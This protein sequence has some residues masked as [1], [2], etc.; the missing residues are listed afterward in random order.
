MVIVDKAPPPG[1]GGMIQPLTVKRKPPN[2][3]SILETKKKVAQHYR[4]PLFKIQNSI[5]FISIS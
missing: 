1:K 3:D 5:Y 2:D 4:I